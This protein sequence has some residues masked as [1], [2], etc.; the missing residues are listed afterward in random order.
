M[1]SFTIFRSLRS[2]AIWSSTGAIAWHGPHHSAQ[3]STS[4]GCSLSSTCLSKLS[5]V[6]ASICFRFLSISGLGWSNAGREAIGPTR[7]D[8]AME[9]VFAPL[10]NVPDHPGLERELLERWDEEETFRRLRE[11]N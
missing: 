1:F 4:T 8:R 3:K 11:Q 10:P 7:Y 5:S 6:I 2:S 9:P